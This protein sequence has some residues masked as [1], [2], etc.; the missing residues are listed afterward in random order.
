MPQPGWL[1]NP[2]WG[3]LPRAT[4]CCRAWCTS[5]PRP[6]SCLQPSSWA[7]TLLIRLGGAGCSSHPADELAIGSSIARLHRFVGND[8]LPSASANSA[9]PSLHPSSLS[10]QETRGACGAQ[11]F[12]CGGCRCLQQGLIPPHPKRPSHPALQGCATATGITPFPSELER[13]Q[14]LHPAQPRGTD[15][16]WG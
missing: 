16:A 3:S 5:L 12:G 13:P 11:G 2:D 1:L 4:S 14:G 7:Q 6:C 10:L 15:P 9:V 8:I